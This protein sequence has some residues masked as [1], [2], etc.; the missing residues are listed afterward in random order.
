MSKCRRIRID[1]N[2][3]GTFQVECEME[4]EKTESKGKGEMAVYPDYETKKFSMGS[5][6]E[7]ETK[8]DS[9]M[10]KGKKGDGGMHQYFTGEKDE[11]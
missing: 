11:E 3:D 10:G 9:M 1:V 4:K 8:M 5:L 6:S 7:L 2:D